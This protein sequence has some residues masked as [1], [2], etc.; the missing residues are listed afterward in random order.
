MHESV[1]FAHIAIVDA[2]LYVCSCNLNDLKR[3]DAFLLSDDGF[4]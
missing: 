1:S 4:A 3:I 2:L